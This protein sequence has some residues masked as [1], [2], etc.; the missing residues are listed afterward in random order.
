MVDLAT[1]ENLRE[2]LRYRAVLELAVDY[3]YA[4]RVEPEGVMVCEWAS[5]G[6]ERLTGY[7]PEALLALGGYDRLIHPDDLPISR[8]RT[9]A[10]LRGEAVSDYLR[11]VT[12]DGQVRWVK[13]TLRPELDAEGRV[14]RLYGVARDVTERHQAVAALHETQQ[15]LEGIL[16][17]SQDGIVML[18]EAGRIATWNSAIEQMTGLAANGVLGLPFIDVL[19]LLQTELFGEHRAEPHPQ[20]LA[21]WLRTGEA[22]WV[23]RLVE[24][25]ITTPDGDRRVVQASSLQLRTSKGWRF[26]FIVRDTTLQAEMLEALRESEQRLRDLASRTGAAVEEERARMAREIHDGLGQTLTAIQ[27]D[28]HWLARRL[29]RA[30]PEVRAKIETMVA[31]LDEAIGSVQELARALRPHLLDD[32]G[33]A[34]TVEWQLQ[35]FSERYGLAYTLRIEPEEPAVERET[36]TALF[37]ILQEALTNVARHAQATAV[38]VILAQDADGVRLTVRDNGRGITLEEAASPNALGLIGMDERAARCGGS[39]DIVGQPGHGTTVSVFIPSKGGT[40]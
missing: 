22:P 30:A 26:G 17:N 2:A 31:E 8:Q 13:D 4:F 27:F 25:H 23:G 28:L 24:G 10:V 3:A 32:L 9:E 21:K 1:Q 6:F 15:M 19:R 11:I 7:T 29:R 39:V 16:D 14:R 34:A 35:R 37:R 18:D 40:T 5:S 20:D 12:R 33:L 36:A 38:E